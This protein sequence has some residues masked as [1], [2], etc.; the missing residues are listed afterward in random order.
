VTIVAS[1]IYFF[2]ISYAEGKKARVSEFQRATSAGDILKP[3]VEALAEPAAG[4]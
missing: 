1:N 2:T 3:P 4:W